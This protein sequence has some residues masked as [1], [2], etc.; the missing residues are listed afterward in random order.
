MQLQKKSK[1]ENL[2]KDNWQTHMPFGEERM[3]LAKGGYM[4]IYNTKRQEIETGYPMKKDMDRL[5]IK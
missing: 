1:L 3:F 4:I 5:E 2:F